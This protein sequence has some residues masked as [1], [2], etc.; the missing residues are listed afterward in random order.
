[1]TFTEI[2]TEVA[3]RLN[4]T[5]TTALARIGRSINECY[6]KV[7][8]S[9]GIQTIARVN[10]VTANTAVGNHNVTFNAIKLLSVYN[11]AYTPP[12]V[13]VEETVETLRQMPQG[14]DPANAWAPLTTTGSTVTI[15]LNVTPASIYTLTADVYAVVA[16]LSGANVPGFAENFHDILVLGS[17]AIELEK[18]EKYDLADRQWAKYH[19]EDGN[20]GRLSELRL[21]LAV[22]AYKD[23]V[24]GGRPTVSQ[25]PPM[26]S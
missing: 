1:M 21:F 20:G 3:E 16:T 7:A 15:M 19:G 13:L 14:T 23:I 17:M 11:A 8:S 18:M 9:I 24:Q 22:S 12:L 5:S 26:V 25:W 4:L 2:Q 10:G 6:K